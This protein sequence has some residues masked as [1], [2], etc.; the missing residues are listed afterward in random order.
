M[1]ISKGTNFDFIFDGPT[2]EYKKMSV[3][4][5][6]N[7]DLV[8]SSFQATVLV[9]NLTFLF[10]KEVRDYLYFDGKN[11]ITDSYYSSDF[12]HKLVLNK[13]CYEMN[14]MVHEAY[15]LGP[16][17]SVNITLIDA[18]YSGPREPVIKHYA[19]ISIYG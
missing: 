7:L 17:Y 2:I 14:C 6:N 12:D 5:D 15:W 16:W 3:G 10:A 19:G 13:S 4:K 9:N 8:L 11:E 18:T 1:E